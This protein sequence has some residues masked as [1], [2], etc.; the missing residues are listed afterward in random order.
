VV[1]A[2]GDDVISPADFFIEVREQLAE[3]LVERDQDV[4]D[5]AAARAELVA[6]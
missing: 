6:D 1:G 4:L 5:F 2:E 3:I